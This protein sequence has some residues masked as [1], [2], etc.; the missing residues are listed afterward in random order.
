MMN[1]KMNNIIVKSLCSVL[2]IFALILSISTTDKI[3][4]ASGDKVGGEV[5][6]E[7]ASGDKVGG[8]VM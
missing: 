7:I 8:E 3:T 4:I 1:K 5:M 2:I 6:I